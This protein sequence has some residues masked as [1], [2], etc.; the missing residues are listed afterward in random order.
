M[1]MFLVIA[2][3]AG[4]E[5]NHHIS[6]T[7]DTSKA[8]KFEVLRRLHAR[9]CQVANEV[10]VLLKS[11]FAEGAHARW[12]TLHEISVF[13][14]IISHHNDDLAERYL[15]HK[16][17]ER[18]KSVELYQENCSK[19]GFEPLTDVEVETLREQST[20]LIARYGQE[21]ENENGWA[22]VALTKKSH[23][24]PQEQTGD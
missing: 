3:E 5:Y 17:I 2:E 11:G 16:I 12:R 1:E 24:F 14:N 23:F 22:A 10:M 13:A 4:A 9:A 8:Y 15:L 19:L 7:T 6:S 21:F 18:Y 20:Q